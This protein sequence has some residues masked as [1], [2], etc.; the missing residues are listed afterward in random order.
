WLAR[1]LLRRERRALRALGGLPGVPQLVTAGAFAAASAH[2][3]PGSVLLRS[4][5][6]G[7][8]LWAAAALPADFFELLA[9][10]VSRLHERSVCHNDLHKENNILVGPDG[11]P[12]VVD[13]QLASVHRRR[14]A[15]FCRRAREDLRH[16]EKHRRRYES[17][18]RLA[19]AALPERSWLA[20][21]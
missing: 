4:F 16:V 3:P 6:P 21:V 1:L 14:G 13:F 18:G 2:L 15:R 20:A 10:L 19:A 12:A 7:E 8:P 5:L 17:E 11:R 9:A